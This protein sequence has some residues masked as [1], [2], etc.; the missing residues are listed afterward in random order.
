[1][2]LS[3]ETKTARHPKYNVTYLRK[4]ANTD[5]DW[6]GHYV[7]NGEKVTKLLNPVNF[8]K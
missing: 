2:S 8:L 1:M 4:Y 6:T 5:E 3:K 7:K